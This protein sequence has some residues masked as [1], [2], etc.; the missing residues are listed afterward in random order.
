[1]VNSTE[2]SSSTFCSTGQPSINS[3]ESSPTYSRISKSLVQPPKL[4][5]F[6][7][8]VPCLKCGNLTSR[9]CQF[10][11]YSFYCSPKCEQ[12][13]LK[14][15]RPVCLE[16]Q[17]GLRA[18]A[19]G[20]TICK[21]C[22]V[23]S[24]KKICTR[25]E[26]ITYCG[27]ECQEKDW[28]KHKPLCDMLYEKSRGSIMNID[29]EVE[30]LLQDIINDNQPR[31]EQGSKYKKNGETSSKEEPV[32]EKL[33]HLTMTSQDTKK[34]ASSWKIGEKKRPG[35]EGLFDNPNKIVRSPPSETNVE[36]AP[37]NTKTPPTK[38]HNTTMHETKKTGEGMLS[39]QK[40]GPEILERKGKGNGIL[41]KAKG[42]MFLRFMKKNSEPALLK[43]DRK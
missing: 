19:Y 22:N 1:M 28:N 35:L 17:S 8:K 38:R 12:M 21:V 14:N 10:C 3:A 23:A 15:H 2:G 11:R 20:K 4:E 5:G 25:C 32:L 6:S 40:S 13:N 43:K 27:E 31:F 16:M 29:P 9:V 26:A 33:A 7:K 42:S 30:S 39:R 41:N 34:K 18:L 37:T 24:A 36:P